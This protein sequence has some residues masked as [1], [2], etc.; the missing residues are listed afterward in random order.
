[1]KIKAVRDLIVACSDGAVRTC[2]PG[3]VISVYHVNGRRLLYSRMAL[4]LE[5]EPFDAAWDP[6][7]A[8]KMAVPQQDKMVRGAMNKRIA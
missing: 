5:R 1:M 3:D 8:F 6:P 2:K 7:E 4:W